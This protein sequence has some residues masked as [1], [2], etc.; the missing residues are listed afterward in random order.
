MTIIMSMVEILLP[1]INVVQAAALTRT[2]TLIIA[3]AAAFLAAP[4]LV[5]AA[6]ARVS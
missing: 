4:V 2:M 3:A 5:T 6:S 1:V